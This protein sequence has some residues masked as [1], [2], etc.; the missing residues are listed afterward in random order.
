MT[1]KNPRPLP[2]ISDEMRERQKHR[3]LRN[4]EVDPITG[5]W[6]WKLAITSAGYGQTSLFSVPWPAHRLSYFLFVGPFD[7]ALDVDHLCR[8][9]ACCNP[10][11]LEAVPAKVN[12]LRSTNHVVA[13]VEATH[14]PQGHPYDG[15]NLHVRP[16]GRR[17]CRA[18][19]REWSTNRYRRIQSGEHVPVPRAVYE[20]RDVA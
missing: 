17:A 9:R 5:C 1:Q 2:V 7:P 15:N 8:V 18:C 4:R 14:C 13:Q 10:E 11:H 6:I 3:L 19:Q 16:S 20:K 12:L